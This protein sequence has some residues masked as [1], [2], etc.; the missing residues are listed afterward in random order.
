MPLALM[1]PEPRFSEAFASDYP[2]LTAYLHANY[3]RSGSLEVRRG[4]VMDVWADTR[5]QGTS[6]TETGLPCFPP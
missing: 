3:R 6:D 4:I 2:V 1:Q 5:R